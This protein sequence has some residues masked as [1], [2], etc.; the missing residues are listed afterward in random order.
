MSFT[1][2]KKNAPLSLFYFILWAWLEVFFYYYETS[3]AILWSVFLILKPPYPL[4]FHKMG[5]LVLQIVQRVLSAPFFPDCP[6]AQPRCVLVLPR[7]N[8][9]VF[10]YTLWV[11]VTGPKFVSGHHPSFFSKTWIGPRADK[12]EK[13]RHYFCTICNKDP[14]FT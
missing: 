12:N 10:L 2:E 11:C 3:S 6:I 8:F 5:P 13:S 1:R 4:F 9:C 7:H 14:F